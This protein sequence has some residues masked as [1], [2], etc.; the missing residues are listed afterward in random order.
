MK[1]NNR[2]I[3][4]CLNGT[5]AMGAKKLPIKLAFAMKHNR[6]E[7]LDKLD[8]FEE[9]RKDIL[10]HYPEGEER[11]AEFAKLLEETVEVDVKKVPIEVVELTDNDGYDKLTLGE[12]ELID[13]MLEA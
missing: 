13:F 8:A 6:K 2:E 9:T 4:T 5:A 3:L 10:E 7:M 12:L 1:L 11:E